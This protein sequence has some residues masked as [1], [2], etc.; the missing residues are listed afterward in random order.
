MS[1][2]EIYQGQTTS[3]IMPLL[4]LKHGAASLTCAVFNISD[5][6]VS[7][8]SHWTS[9]IVQDFSHFPKHICNFVFVFVSR[10]S[11]LPAFAH[12]KG[13]QHCSNNRT[14]AIFDYRDVFPV[15]AVTISVMILE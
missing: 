12:P 6:P 15:S 5:F 11:S 2:Q 4:K 9:T 3:T 7:L 10:I 8:S 1:E 14:T 13:V